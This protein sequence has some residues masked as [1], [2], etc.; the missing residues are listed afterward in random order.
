[1]ML[2]AM[3]AVAAVSH[4][5]NAALAR[6]AEEEKKGQYEEAVPDYR[7]ALRASAS[8]ASARLGLGRA[9]AKLGQ[10][11]DAARILNRLPP[12]RSSE[13]TLLVGVCRFRIREF[14]QAIE[15]LQEAVHFEPQNSQAW[16]FLAR[17]YSS[18]GNNEKA[19]STLKRWT[20]SRPDDIDALYWIG[21]L[22]HRLANQTFQQMSAKDPQSYLVYE[23]EGKQFR[24]RQQYAQALTAYEKALALAPPRSPGLHFYL[25]DAYWRTLRFTEAQAEL[26]QELALNPSH[27]KAN[28]EMGDIYAKEDDPRQAIPYLRKALALD[29]EL[30]QA[31]RSLGRAYIEN[32]Q[33]QRALEEFLQVENAEPDDHTIHAQLANTYRLLGQL[34]KARREAQLS[35]Q[36]ENKAIQRIQRSKAAE[37]KLDRR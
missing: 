10:C 4:A 16:I 2:S 18:A 12:Q 17:A 28:F 29:P 6:A 3:L 14:P 30:T 20:R 15:Q 25:G 35:Q 34:T 8:S 33:Y 24:I 37:L 32:R 36:L 21:Q 22:Y 9:L 11:D 7:A 1:M 27:S 19:I 5:Q 31:H 13:T 26:K 23:T